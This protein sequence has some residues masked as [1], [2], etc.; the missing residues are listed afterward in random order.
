MT[1][2]DL[3]DPWDD[4]PCNTP[5]LAA[6][7][8]AIRKLGL[9]ATAAERML[10]GGNHLASAVIQFTSTSDGLGPPYG[11]SH[12]EARLLI[13]DVNHYDCWVAWKAIMEF[14]DEMRKILGEK[15]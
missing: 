6:A 5:R 10:V 1:E 12:E 9:L 15:E 4:P 13:K 11:M 14:R 2:D 8:D 3:Y 7:Q